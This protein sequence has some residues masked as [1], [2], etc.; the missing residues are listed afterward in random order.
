MEHEPFV[1]S[2][3]AA[4][5]YRF[6]LNEEFS[7]FVEHRATHQLLWSPWGAEIFGIS[8]SLAFFGALMSS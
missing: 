1:G 7:I 8:N 5:V 4:V 6:G 3:S 2:V